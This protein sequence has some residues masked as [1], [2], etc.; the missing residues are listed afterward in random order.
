MAASSAAEPPPPATRWS[1]PGWKSRR[2]GDR[3]AISA[4]R[5]RRPAAASSSFACRRSTIDCCSLRTTEDVFLLAWGTDQL[6]L[7]RRGPR[8]ASAAGPPARPTGTDSAA[9]PP[10]DP[11]QAEGQAD[12]SPGRADGGRAR[13]PPRAMPRKALAQGLAGKLPESWRP[14]EE[15]AAVEIWLTI[16]GAHGGV[17]PAAVRPHHA[18]SHL[19]AG[20]S[21]G[22]AAADDG[23]GDGAPGRD[24]AAARRPRSD[25]RRRHDPGRAIWLPRQHV[26]GGLRRCWA[27][28]SSP[29][30]CAPP[31]V[32]LR[33]L[34]RLDSARWDATRLPLEDAAVDRV[35]SNPPFGKQLSS[36]EEI[37][38]L[39]RAHG[40]RVRPRAASGRP[41][42]AAGQRR[43]GAARGR[44]RRRL[45]STTAPVDPRARTTGH[46]YSL[47]EAGFVG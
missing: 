40:A 3:A 21:A 8:Q 34:G 39:Y 5:S 30:P 29:A 19:Q 17:R 28:T 7:P 4:A 25:V 44:S 11:A 23:G 13:L 2:R 38:P 36:P 15:N 43:G 20:A 31:A 18:A 35:V 22:V 33:R 6:T 41:G 32:N 24:P 42:G 14:A 9:P 26:R 47:A 1:I 10:R 45:A 27:A 37:G 12:L 46:R 16:H